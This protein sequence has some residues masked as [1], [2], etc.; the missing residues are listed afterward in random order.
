M[1]VP[2]A[3][4]TRQQCTAFSRAAAQRT[5]WAI[6]LVLL[7]FCQSARPLLAGLALS[8]GMKCGRD[9]QSCCCRKKKQ[10]QHTSVRMAPAA[11]CD[12]SCSMG[13]GRG[14]G[15]SAHR[16]PTSVHIDSLPVLHL[17]ES[18][19]AVHSVPE[20]KGLIHRQRPPPSA[21]L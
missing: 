15:A 10:K 17:S 21:S 12:R 7:M 1:I 5:V 16:L 13:L 2:A 9:S 11:S 4:S 6:I 8:C 14:A 18:H 3:P 19:D 20:C